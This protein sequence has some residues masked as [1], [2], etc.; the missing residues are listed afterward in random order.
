M[1]R[2]AILIITD[3][4]GVPLG[5]RKA[6]LDQLEEMGYN[7][8][9]KKEQL[10]IDEIAF[11]FRRTQNRTQ[12]VAHSHCREQK[13][14]DNRYYFIYDC[15]RPDA[16]ILTVLKKFVL[17]V[18]QEIKNHNMEISDIKESFFLFKSLKNAI[19]NN[20]IPQNDIRLIEAACKCFDDKKPVQL[21]AG[22]IEKSIYFLVELSSKYKELKY[23]IHFID[24]PMFEHAG[25]IHVHIDQSKGNE[26]IPARQF[27]K[28]YNE[29]IK[30]E[31]QE[32][33]AKSESIK[34]E[35]KEGFFQKKFLSVALVIGLLAVGYW[36]LAPS[37]SNSIPTL[38]PAL[39]QNAT[40]Y[41]GGMQWYRSLDKGFEIAQKEN[42]PIAVYFLAEWCTFCE[43][44]QSKTLGDTQVKKVLEED[45]VL[46][47]MDLDID[48]EVANKYGVNT[49]P[50][51]LFLDGNGRIIDRISGSVD[52]STILSIVTQVRD[53]LV[54]DLESSPS[55]SSTQVPS[56]NNFLTTSSKRLNVL[57]YVFNNDSGAAAT[58]GLER[59]GY[60]QAFENGNYRTVELGA[61][62]YVAVNG[63][64]D[65]LAKLVMEQKSEDIKTMAIGESWD[66]GGGWTLTANSI[67]ARAA[68]RQAWLTLS[69]DGVKKDEKVITEKEIYTYVEKSLADETDVPVFVTYID[70]IFAAAT[71][72]M[73]QL[74]YTWAIDPTVFTIKAGEKYGDSE[75]VSIDKINNRLELKPSLE[76]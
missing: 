2:N 42:K 64:I 60:G 6:N 51:I 27:K 39:S 5:D 55:S 15:D 57:T 10:I 41:L 8:N 1:S 59:T 3:S 65:V 61:N 46:V 22:G 44:F 20:Q 50:Y 43:E 17:K 25:S 70:S 49:A 45:F 63:K 67:D 16:D 37:L 19:S 47:M 38:E 14:R 29:L 72:D 56:Q 36:G 62:N 71:T 28:L 13:K 73:A 40:G 53:R 23:I 12:I 34:R 31:K 76:K 35:N 48:K 9:K 26:I 33:L 74:K 68:P 24:D 30:Q 11:S 4:M 58:A 52:A 21:E 32:P 69:K 75:V 54:K 18:E 66:I 7:I